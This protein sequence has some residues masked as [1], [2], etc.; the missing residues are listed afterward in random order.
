MIGY[1]EKTAM[2]A[3]RMYNSVTSTVME[4]GDV[5]F[6]A[7]ITNTANNVRLTLTHQVFDPELIVDE[8]DITLVEVLLTEPK[9]RK[10]T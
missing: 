2:D 3:Y 8:I 6:W 1:G 5:H 10:Q 4:T 7:G 9:V